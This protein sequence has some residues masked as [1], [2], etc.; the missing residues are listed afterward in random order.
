MKS[1]SKIN[2]RKSLAILAL[3][4]A[5]ALTEGG[6]VADAARLER[7]FPHHSWE[8]ANPAEFVQ[9]LNDEVAAE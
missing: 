7:Y 2:Y 1:F 8:R 4:G 5:L 9:T 6:M 3:V